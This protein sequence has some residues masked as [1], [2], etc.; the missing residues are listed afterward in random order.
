MADDIRVAAFIHARPGQEDAVRRAALACVP[1]TRAE[2]GNTEYVLH[3]DARDPSL[4]VFI[5]GWTSVQALD[6]HLE[7]AHVKALSAALEGRLVGPVVLH[8]LTPV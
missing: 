8:V 1:P 6:E 3:S 7:T 2:P 5:E 4:F